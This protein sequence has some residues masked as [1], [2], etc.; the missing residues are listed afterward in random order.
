[1]RGSDLRRASFAV[2]TVML[3][4]AG[5]GHAGDA[6]CR[7]EYEQAEKM[8]WAAV[9]LEVSKQDF[10]NAL[11]ELERCNASHGKSSR[12][13]DQRVGGG[14]TQGLQ[15]AYI[16]AIRLAV[17]KNWVP[18]K[19]LPNASCVVHITQLPGGDLMAVKVDE[20]C[21]FDTQGRKALEQAIKL[22]QPLP[23]KGYESV[24]QRILDVSFHP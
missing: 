6:T 8:R 13:G 2:S 21:P 15:T 17:S 19:N 1:M 20:A 4:L 3:L 22:A 10:M 23:Y 9:R 12:A 16:D 14:A 5:T 11:M 24:W 18:P 7:K